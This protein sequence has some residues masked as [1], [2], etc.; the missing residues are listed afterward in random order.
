MEKPSDFLEDSTMIDSKQDKEDTTLDSNLNAE[1]ACTSSNKDAVTTDLT[2]TSHMDTNMSIYSC[3][4]VCNASDEDEL[5]KE[6]IYNEQQVFEGKIFNVN[7]LDVKLPSGQHAVRDVVRHPGAVGIIAL[8]NKGKITLV[9]QYRAALDRVTLEI[10]AGKLEAGEDPLDAAA[11]ELLEETG[12]V[13]KRIAYLTTI[14]SSVG[15]SDER[16]ALYLA[17]ELKFEGANPDDDEFINVDLMEVGELV[18]AVLDGRIEDAKTVVGA[19]I[20]DSIG[21]R[22]DA[23]SSVE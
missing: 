5:L 21:H 16:I 19:L 13:A 11:R 18:D 2:E 14:A 9:R 1:C 3:E 8:T 17:T 4:E 12:F 23:E 20:C 7:R 10:P 6:T 22:L 15:F